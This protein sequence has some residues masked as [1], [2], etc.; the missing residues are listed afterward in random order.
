MKRKATGMAEQ[1]ECER[2]NEERIPLSI[3]QKY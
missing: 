1:S 2:E 3:A